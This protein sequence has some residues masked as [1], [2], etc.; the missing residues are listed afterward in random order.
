MRAD[1]L[2][3]LQ[4]KIETE[5]QRNYVVESRVHPLQ[6]FWTGLFVKREDEL[7][8][9][10]SG[11][12]IR[13]YRTLIPFL[14]KNGYTEIGVIGGPFSNNV[15]SI[16]Q[17]LIE[18]GLIPTLFLHG[19]K[20]SKS[21]GNFAF[22]EL[23]VKPTAIHWIGKVDPLQL[24]ETYNSYRTANRNR[25]IIPEG[26]LIFPSCIGACTL[27]LDII[28][29]E[30]ELNTSFEEIFI[31]SGT[32]LTTAALLLVFAF[33]EKETMVHVL[34]LAEKKEAFHRTLQALHT[35]FSSW[36]GIDVPFPSRYTS[37][38]PTVAPSFGSTNQTLF[39]FIQD[40]ATREGFFLDPI[41][42]AKLFFEVQKR[43]KNSS[44]KQLIIHSG[45]ALSLSGFFPRSP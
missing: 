13:K 40:I 7:G 39:R 14:H 4:K 22:L 29:N 25:Y 35:E 20:P 26:A 43:G 9:G 37:F 24:Q 34:H 30:R 44:N 1:R 6:T 19:R 45:G 27:P 33:L 41:Y 16:T 38:F 12:K 21:V 15:L 2:L 32:G 8:F 23:L 18:E 31:D 10:I 42:S 11:S 5:P 17:L 36:L 3:L 28:R